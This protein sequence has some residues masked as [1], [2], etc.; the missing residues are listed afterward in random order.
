MSQ[1]ATPSHRAAR[2][3]RPCNENLPF[4]PTSCSLFSLGIYI[5]L[6]QG[7]R[8]K[9]YRSGM[10]SLDGFSCFGP[11][12]S[13]EWLGLAAPCLAQN[14]A[15]VEPLPIPGHPAQPGRGQPCR[16]TTRDHGHIQQAP[17]VSPVP[18]ALSGICLQDLGWLSAHSAWSGQSQTLPHLI[19]TAREATGHPGTPKHPSQVF[20]SPLTSALVQHGWSSDLSYKTFP[21]TSL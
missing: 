1:A 14:E 18:T 9:K 21:T 3:P 7:G 8:D 19:C 4:Q 16:L 17:K 10:C 2:I 6:C 12:A 13:M 11:P 5:T 20:H 15:A